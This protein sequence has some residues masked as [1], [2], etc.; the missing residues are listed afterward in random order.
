VI[1]NKKPTFQYLNVGLIALN[2][3]I[4]ISIKQGPKNLFLAAFNISGPEP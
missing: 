4:T 3:I 2:A 1:S